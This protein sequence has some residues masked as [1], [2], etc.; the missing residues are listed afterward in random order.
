MWKP[1]LQHTRVDISHRKTGG[2]IFHSAVCIVLWFGS[3]NELSLQLSHSHG[4]RNARAP[5]HQNQIRCSLVA[6]TKTRLQI[7]N[8]GHQTYIKIPLQEIL[9]SGHSG[10]TV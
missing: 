2:F 1:V 6:A 9:G 5:G 3:Y 10:K 8:P 7:Q 4:T